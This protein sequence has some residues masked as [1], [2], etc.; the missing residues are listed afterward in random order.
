MHVPC[1]N[2]YSWCSTIFPWSIYPPAIPTRSIVLLINGGDS[3]AGLGS[4]HFLARGRARPCFL[5]YP[6]PSSGVPGGSGM[7]SGRT[8]DGRLLGGRRT[9][10]GLGH[11][12]GRLPALA[13]VCASGGPAAPGWRWRGGRLAVSKLC[14]APPDPCFGYAFE[15]RPGLSSG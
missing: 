4:C 2:D 11:R 8:P 3:P 12:L 6:R 1:A 15:P 7:P 9:A 13:K 14:R 5:L 10:L